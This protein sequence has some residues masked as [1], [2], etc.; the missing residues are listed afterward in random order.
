MG[1]LS[2]LWSRLVILFIGKP[3]GKIIKK[4]EFKA[5]G[6]ILNSA[7]ISDIDND[8]HMEIIIGTSK[9]KIFVLSAKGKVKWEGSLKKEISGVN[10]MFLDEKTVN[11]IIASPV[12]LKSKGKIIIVACSAS[13]IV[14]AFHGDGRS[15]WE[16]KI[17]GIIFGTPLCADVN[18]DGEK[19]II[20]GT[21]DHYLYAI[22]NCGKLLWKYC[23]KSPITSSPG[24][25]EDK[26][27][28]ILFGT[29]NGFLK[30]VSIN[31]K[32]RWKFKTKGKITARPVISDIFND[33]HKRIIVG[34][35]DKSLYVL[36]KFGKL[37]WEYKTHGEIFSHVT[38]GDV[39]K[40]K[41]KE[42]FF[43]AGDDNIYALA[44]NS[45]KIWS[46]ETDFWVV[47]SP[48]ITDINGD[49]TN[50][51]V[52]GSYDKSV[53]VL[54]GK[55]TF[56]LNYM[57]GLSI[58]ASLPGHFT[59]FIT[60]QPGELVGKRLWKIRLGSMVTGL[61]VI[62]SKNLPTQVIVSTKGGKLY[63]LGHEK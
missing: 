49:G 24:F 61:N 9:G 1:I 19:E 45:Q 36:N 57:P 13:G 29:D 52:V 10:L 58:I 16:F 8:G 11:S 59:P 5:G 39:D 23:A 26:P 15:F 7:T 2:R 62:G 35:T 37:D 53:Y 60:S 14:K 46:Y 42:I 17:Q 4:W 41:D 6:A 47:T 55:G 51:I 3:P 27:K 40:D 20:F 30:A 12:I 54:E 38:I 34:S 33:K 63:C 22:T 43:G 31:G 48:I 44:P 32:F 25:Y 18:N 50:E 28:L 56:A 21:S